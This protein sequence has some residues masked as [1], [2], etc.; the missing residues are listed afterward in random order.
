MAIAEAAGL[1]E[2]KRGRRTKRF[3]AL[4]VAPQVFWSVRCSASVHL[5]DGARTI[6]CRLTSGR[7][8]GGI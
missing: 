1:F 6:C 3:F 2:Y 8:P 4:F 7:G 5:Y